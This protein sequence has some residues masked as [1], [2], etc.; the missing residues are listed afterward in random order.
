MTDYFDRVENGLCRAVTEGQHM[1][2][3]RRLTIRRRSLAV[4][5]ASLVLTGS[6]LAASGVFQTGAPVG[7]EV[8]PNP[9]TNMGVAIPSS[10]E[11]LPLRI[12]DP[13]GGPPWG[14]RTIK[15]TRGLVCVQLGRI[16]GGRIGV[17][18]QDGAFNDDGRFH[19]LSINHL[20]GGFNCATQDAH[21]HAFLNEEDFSIPAAGLIAGG[22]KVSGGCYTH[23]NRDRCPHR[24]LRDISYG[25]LGPKA[26]GITYRA[27]DGS[28]EHTATAG[29]DGAY[30]V[31]LPHVER[32]C[33]E[34]TPIS[35]MRGPG[36]ETGSPRVSLFGAIRAISYR[37]GSTC[38]LMTAEQ[39]KA[40]MSAEQTQF[41]SL[42]RARY[43]EIYERV[44]A[45]GENPEMAP[46]S[47]LTPS[48]TRAFNAL[49]LPFERGFEHFSC[50]TVGY[51]PLPVS[52]ITRAQIAAPI[53]VRF[54]PSSFYCEKPGEQAVPCG[55][56][57]PAGYR[58]IPGNPSHPEELVVISF[59]TRI[60]IKNYD[61]HYEINIAIPASANH[62]S[63]PQAGGGSFGPS[64]SDFTVGQE[65][66]FNQFFDP[67]CTGLYRV[68]VGLVTVNGPSGDM[69][70]PGLPGQSGEASV[71]QTDIMIYDK[72]GRTL[73][74]RTRRR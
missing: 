4:V 44:Y 23:R 9:T 64:N 5:V 6:A 42:L 61:R 1:P 53:H 22:P 15:T 10:V 35:C 49:R 11:L 57:T 30:L 74:V 26:S 70:V 29:S 51:A 19:P 3:Y 46:L 45:S 60:A 33:L 66:R 16:V 73:G 27:A 37:D 34:E 8:P 40:A 58:R 21:G 31:V 54:E 25:L 24:D 41:R 39:V 56:R 48:Q 47:R 17:L 65:V 59:R 7:P 13:V 43:P 62:R 52:H 32:R 28:L 18:G 20:E 67:R 14:L 55:R 68:T 71:G 36:G 72:R 38:H 63:C 69:P 50:P 12:A 2:W